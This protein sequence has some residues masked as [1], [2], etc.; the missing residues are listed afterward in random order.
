MFGSDYTNHLD[1]LMHSFT[2]MTGEYNKKAKK[3]KV[4]PFVNNLQKLYIKIFG[5][6]EIG[7][8]IRNLYFEKIVKKHLSDY[9]AKKILDAGCG[10]GIYT[11]ALRRL[12]PEAIIEGTD[13]D[14]NK[15]QFC[16]D[17]TKDLH[18]ENMN[19]SYGD[20]AKPVRKKGDYNLIVHI[21]VLEHIENYKQVIKNFHALL[22][23]KGYVFIHTPQV[24]QTRIFKQFKKWH[25]DDHKHEGFS[26]EGLREEMEKQGF[27][28][29]QLNN[30]HGPFGKLAWELNHMMLAKSF[31]LTGL[32]Y[33][34]LYLLGKID[35]VFPN[36]SGLALALLAQ[37]KAE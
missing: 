9:K 18:M 13:I 19:F 32:F 10:I 33:P 31:V 8:Q 5:I 16:K 3:R 20:S 15:L 11:I 24:N 2:N 36:R 34:F 30:T 25:H 14:K 29:V 28:V 1:V 17:I 37:K 12:Y 4:N 7:L 6:P 26:P 21:D 22:A 35:S 27:K 23:P